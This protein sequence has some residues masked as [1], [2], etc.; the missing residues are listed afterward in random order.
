MILVKLDRAPQ[1]TGTSDG[2][3]PNA[4]LLV[5]QASYTYVPRVLRLNIG[6]TQVTD[7][8][9]LGFDSRLLR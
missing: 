6:R 9:S 5:P 2:K 4:G 3:R 7:E 8:H 1:V